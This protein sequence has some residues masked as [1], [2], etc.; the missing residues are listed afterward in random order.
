LSEKTRIRRLPERG[1]RDI[2]AINSILDEGFVCHAAYVTDDRPVVI[3]TLYARDDHR[4]LLHGSNSMGLARAVRSG[5]PLSVAVTHVDGL[6]VA[7]SAFNSSANYRSVVVHG[8]G[9][10]LDGRE[11]SAALDTVIDK[12]LPG[13]RADLRPS[14]EE[15]IAQTSVIEL[16]LD[17]VSAKVRSGGPGD[18]PEDMELAVWAGVV[19]FRFEAGDP[20]PAEDLMDGLQTPDYLRSFR[21]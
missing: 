2:E 21:R 7:R 16:S 5:S 14:T 8:M 3:P 19:P 17:E 6:V 20:I 18:D 9:R 15:E 13:R 12:V 10:L 1:V 11:K 4:L